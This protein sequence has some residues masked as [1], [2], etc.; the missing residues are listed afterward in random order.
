M[1]K[2]W[3]RRAIVAGGVSAGGV[4]LAT[5]GSKV[6]GP[7]MSTL[8]RAGESASLAAHRVLLDVTGQPLAREFTRADISAT[9][10]AIGTT[11][12]EDETYRRH[13]ERNFSTWRLRVDGLVS[14]PLSL[15]V[16]ELRSMPSRTQ[17]TAHSCERGW[18]AIAEWTGVQ[19]A[20]VLE[21]AGPHREAKYVVIHCTDGWYDSYRLDEFE[22]L[23][24]QT[25]LAW[26]M[27]GGDLPVRHGAPIRLRIERQLGWKSVKFVERLQLV[28]DF[29]AIGSGTGS[30]VADF[31]FQWYGGI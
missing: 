5:I 22:A 16:N 8:Y 19:L 20:R 21:L 11:M 30:Y 25:I 27:N 15:S 29:G 17:I 26:G 18:T 24:P 31:G 1:K 14:K 23:H 13:L 7:V 2:T 3:T 4:L 9:F 12:P 6:A 10:P 28:R